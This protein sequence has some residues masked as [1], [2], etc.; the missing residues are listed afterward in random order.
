MYVYIVSLVLFK[1]LLSVDIKCGI[2]HCFNYRYLF[3]CV[4]DLYV[5]EYSCITAC[6][7]VLN[8]LAYWW[9][10]IFP[11]CTQHLQV[12]DTEKKKKTGDKRTARELLGF[13]KSAG[14]LSVDVVKSLSFILG[15][16]VQGE[17]LVSFFDFFMYVQNSPPPFCETSCYASIRDTFVYFSWLN[18]IGIFPLCDP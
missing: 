6:I 9:S 8:N 15:A 16:S 10:F 12:E 13:M 5:Y 2:D 17:K 7:W 18:T 4:C 1:Y 11:S 3:L 14:V